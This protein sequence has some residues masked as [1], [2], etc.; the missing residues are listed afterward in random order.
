MR[1][2]HSGTRDGRRR[3][4]S[5]VASAWLAG[6]SGAGY[7]PAV[8][9]AD[10]ADGSPAPGPPELLSTVA[11]PRLLLELNALANRR[12][13]AL[14]GAP[15]CDIALY[16]LRYTTRAGTAGAAPA[17]TVLMVPFGVDPAC[18][19]ARPIILYA[20]GE[21]TRSAFDI[22][23]WR[24]EQNAEGLFAAAFFAAQGYIVVAP[25]FAGYDGPGPTCHSCTVA[26][27]QSR[28]MIDALAAGRRALR[29]AS[30]L[31]TR[32]SGRL[33]ITGYSRGGDVAAS[34]HR[35]LLAAGVAVTG[36]AAL[37]G[38]YAPAAF[39]DIAQRTAP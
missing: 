23:N 12:L 9:G 33:F 34:T 20:H 36:S 5:F 32:A 31:L 21:A 8:S 4:G 37:S 18:R 7:T 6:C 2:W 3:W 14:S 25:D 24:D 26:D 10:T 28:D 11:A 19:G 35:A 13:L 39:A 15:L 1:R 27:R 17:S 16:R 38:P 29:T 22:V 30:P